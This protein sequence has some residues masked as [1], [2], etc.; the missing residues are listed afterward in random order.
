MG[1]EWINN[2]ELRSVK[3]DL[4]FLAIILLSAG[5]IIGSKISYENQQEKDEAK[6][7]SISNQSTQ[8][9]ETD[10][11]ETVNKNNSFKILIRTKKTR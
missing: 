7:E 9:V 1:D 2:G 11:E 8:D 3:D 10:V 6:Q 5:I 4:F